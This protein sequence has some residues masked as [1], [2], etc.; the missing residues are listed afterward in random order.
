[1]RKT[2][3]G[4]KQLRDWPRLNLLILAVL[5]LPE[6]RIQ[7]SSLDTIGLTLL[8]ATTTNLDGTGIYVSQVEGQITNSPPTWEVDPD[9]VSVPAGNFTYYASGGSSTNYTN[10]LG[11]ESAHAD[12]VGIVLYGPTN[13]V[14]TNV[15]HINN[16]EALYFAYTVVANGMA[17]HSRVVNQSF[18]GASSQQYLL[19]TWYDNYSAQNGTLFISSAG[20]SGA[21]VPPSTCYNGIGVAAY[22][23]ASSMGPTPDNGRAKP[24]ITAPSDTTSYSA[25]L[26]SGAAAL[27]LQAGL[28]GDG[29]ADTN[30]AADART[31]KALLL[32][33]AIKPLDWAAPGPSPLDPRYG[34]GILN[35]FNSYKQ[36][37]GGKHPY[38][39][40]SSATAGDPNPPTGATGNVSS[41]SGWDFNS[42]TNTA[43]SNAV[44]HYYFNLTNSTG[45]GPFTA[46]ATL[47]WN[48]QFAQNSINDLDLYLY[49]AD[50]GNLVASSTS[51]VDNVEHIFIPTLPP[52]RYDLQVLKNGG[53]TVSPDETYALAFE[54]FTMPLSLTSSGGNV[55][56]TW[57]VYPDGF[58][59]ESSPV[60]GSNTSWSGVSNAPVVTNNQNSITVNSADS[61]F[62]RL[63]RP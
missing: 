42:I 9:S 2:A 57:P 28:R 17:T 12:N 4:S 32:N 49:D 24:D 22:H 35:V 40:S 29:G 37:A 55:V 33:G 51:Q 14:S 27:L 41:L 61:Q 59:L 58:V 63:W 10:S 18:A 11:V 20:D 26:V 47:V 38:I 36:L 52:G 1:V 15:A 45:S 31:I 43:L 23:G 19:D 25:P 7:A 30:S 13:G 53:A 44:Y 46:T 8:R 62:F 5:S 3:F 6:A 60:V 39:D 34:A 48:R 50:S 54:F 56:L 21:V 16:Y